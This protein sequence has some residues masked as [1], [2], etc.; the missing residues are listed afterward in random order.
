R[1]DGAVLEAAAD[2]GAGPLRTFVSVALP[3]ARSGVAAGCLLVF[4]PAVGEFVVPDLLGGPDTLMAGRLLWD[5][6]FRN[7]DWPVASA[8]A[9]TLLGA[10]LVPMWLLQRLRPDEAAS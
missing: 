5:E 10:L 7:A 8:L 4:I 6:F 2:L 9:L 1:L 3:M